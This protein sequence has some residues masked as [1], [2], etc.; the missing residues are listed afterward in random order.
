MLLDI[1]G[2]LTFNS[3]NNTVHFGTVVD[4]ADPK[5]L[6]RIKVK[7][8]MIYEMSKEDMPWVYPTNY[9]P[10]NFY[11]PKIGEKVRVQ[12][13]DGDIYHPEY[14]GYFHNTE[15]HDS[16][17]DTDYPHSMGMSQDGFVF[18]YNRQSE[19][20][21]LKAKNGSSLTM[22]KDGDILFV[23]K[24]DFGI[25]SDG[26]VT[27]SAKADISF[28]TDAKFIVNGKGGV[29]ITSDGEAKFSGKAK[30][31]IGSADSQTFVNGQ[32]VLLAG[33]GLSIATINSQCLGIGNL[34]APVVSSIIT[35]SSKVTA[36]L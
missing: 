33:G 24:K 22:N 12:F 3:E 29:E 36:P 17:F 5:K 31:E 25:T 13:N 34:G 16:E 23:V 19:L 4:N 35:G 9:S 27:V 6:G 2:V 28:S 1:D 15:N 14:T 32:M 18:K 30:T 20:F 7:I 21:E 26:K 8:D 10:L 11:V